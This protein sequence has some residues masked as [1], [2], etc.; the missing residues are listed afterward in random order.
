MSRWR[1][2]DLGEN[3]FEVRLPADE[4]L[5][6]SSLATELG[7]LLEGAATAPRKSRHPRLLD[8]VTAESLSR[9]SPPTYPRDPE[10]EAT[11]QASE[12]EILGRHRQIALNLAGSLATR[13]YLDEQSLSLVLGAVNDLRLVLGAVLGV[14]EEEDWP[15][16]G[17]PELREWLLYGY[18]SGLASEIVD[19]LSASLPTS[20]EDPELPE[21]PWGEPPGDLR[22][23]GTLRPEWPPRPE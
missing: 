20:G 16:E 23:D 6:I 4:A 8:S 18:L 15:D 17:D 21:D 2:R 22:W 11:F 19:V 9:L 7:E 1:F 5:L 10:A 12:R 14:S 3:G 13:S